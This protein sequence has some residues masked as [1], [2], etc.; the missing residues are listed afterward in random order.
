L[1]FDTTV[2]ELTPFRSLEQT[3]GRVNRHYKKRDSE[4]VIVDVDDNHWRLPE[5]ESYLK[6]VRDTLSRYAGRA[7]T[8]EQIRNSIK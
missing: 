8:W 1:N 2:V 7:T 5:E 6:E 3:L 4:I